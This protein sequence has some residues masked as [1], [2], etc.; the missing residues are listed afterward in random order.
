MIPEQLIKFLMEKGL[1]SAPPPP[2]PLLPLPVNGKMPADYK[3]S[4][5]EESRR[6]GIINTTGVRG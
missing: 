2:K 5:L 6:K 3:P 4:E 1:L